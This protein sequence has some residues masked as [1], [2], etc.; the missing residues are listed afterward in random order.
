MKNKSTVLNSVGWSMNR[1]TYKQSPTTEFVSTYEQKSNKSIC[2]IGSKKCMPTTFCYIHHKKLDIPSIRLSFQK[3]TPTFHRSGYR[4][5]RR[6]CASNVYWQWIT[7]EPGDNAMQASGSTPCLCV[8][9]AAVAA[10]IRPSPPFMTAASPSRR[11]GCMYLT[12]WC[13]HQSAI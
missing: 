2:D 8:W 5:T 11:P 12:T 9:S 3:P 7:K 4:A 6:T 13:I 10:L 1:K